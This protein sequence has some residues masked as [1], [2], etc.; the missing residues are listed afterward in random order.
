M[1]YSLIR[2]NTMPDSQQSLLG[3]FNRFLIIPMLFL[4]TF[5]LFA[6]Q[7]RIQIN[8]PEGSLSQKEVNGVKFRE[9]VGNVVIT[10]GNMRTTCDQAIYYYEKEEAELIGNVVCV[11]DTITIKTPKGY[12]Y[13]NTRMVFSESGLELNDSHYTL[14]AKKG[15]YYFNEKRADFSNQVVLFDKISNV[16]AD[17]LT[18]FRDESKAV[19]VG[20]VQVCDTSTV[21]FADSLI[22]LREKKIS[23][24]YKNVKMFSPSNK[25]IMLA[26]K[27]E[28]NDSTGYSR[29]TERPFFIQVDS[30]TEGKLDTLYMTSKTMEAFQDSTDRFTATDSVK[31][32]RNNFSTVNSMTL[33]KRKDNKIFTNRLEGDANP[34]VLWYDNSQLIG[35][36]ISIHIE[37]KKLKQIQIIQNAFMLSVNEGFEYRYDQISGRN[38]LMRFNEGEIK[39]IDI[40]GNLLSI[41]YLYDGK[42]ANGLV[43][44]SSEKG[45][46]FFNEKKIEDVKLY[47]S[48]VSD[49]NPENIILGKEKDFTLPGFV[50]YKNKPRKEEFLTKEV[51]AALIKLDEIIKNSDGKYSNI[52]RREPKKSL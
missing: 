11:Q 3:S 18:Y 13:G 36:S 9:F 43:K 52:K 28:T 6:Q 29:I 33:F 39:Q 21:V 10:Q 30:T 15:Y 31:I 1:K 24:G 32:F 2:N 12:Y 34:P 48:V 16:I 46:L 22:R 8:A 7:E 25:T 44:S 35:D 38:I 19:A 49:Y 20:N 27:F 50:I 51:K 26:D 45:K 14:R 5:N 4:L 41:Y 23:Y 40:E 42:E 17:K 47:G 37:E